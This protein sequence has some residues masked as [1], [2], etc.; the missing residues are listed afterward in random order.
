MNVS[1]APEFDIGT[2]RQSASIL[3]SDDLDGFHLDTNGIFAEQIQGVVHG[4]QFG[5]TLSISHR[6]EKF[7]LSVEIW[8][9]SQPFLRS[10]ALG[11][12]WAVSYSLHKIWRWTPDSITD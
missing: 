7:T 11:N 2:L 9:F 6:I 1:V 12:L 5:Q 4:A 10:N 3:L 8:Q